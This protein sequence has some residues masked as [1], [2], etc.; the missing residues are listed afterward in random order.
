MLFLFAIGQGG[1]RAQTGSLTVETAGVR[2]DRT[3][4]QIHRPIPMT[5][6]L[7]VL[8]AR[9]GLDEPNTAEKPTDTLAGAEIVLFEAGACSTAIG[10]GEGGVEAGTVQPVAR[11]AVKPTWA[12][13]SV[14]GTSGSSLTKIDLADM[15]PILWTGGAETKKVMLAQLEVGGVR[16]GAPVVL[17]PMIAPAYS[18]RTDRTGQPM[19]VEPEDRA[20]TF[21]GIRAWVSKTVVMETNFGR[22]EFAMRPDEAPNTVWHFVQLVRDGFYT[23]I[24]VHRIASLTGSPRPDIVQAGDPIGNGLGG[25]GFYADLEPSRLKHD[26][27]VLSMARMSDPNT[28]GSQFFICLSR[29]GT[30]SLDGKYTSFGQLIGGEETLGAIA[31]SPVGPDQKPLNPPTISRMWLADAPPVGRDK[32]PL[33]DPYKATNGR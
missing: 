18:P 22:L 15:F 23:D 21:S 30:Q 8:E 3:Y 17:Q 28:N 20:K 2:P 14:R 26:Y 25:P 29:A 24:P 13:P 4:Y 9:P 11:A 1:A 12:A 19:F 33:A 31:K 7:G 5:V 16:R 6:D 32:R 27:G 10:S